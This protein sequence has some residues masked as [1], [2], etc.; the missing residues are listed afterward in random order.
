[1][2]GTRSFTLSIDI[3]AKLKDE[4]NQSNLVEMLLWKHY[5][6]KEPENKIAS[7]VIEQVKEEIAVKNEQLTKIQ[8]EAKEYEAIA[9][10]INQY[11]MHNA[12]LKYLR[13]CEKL[14]PM[15]EVIET[16]T[17]LTGERYPLGLTDAEV[18]EVHALIW[19]LKGMEK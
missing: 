10:Q 5:A 1:M 15:I 19:K 8:R 4:P 14:P 16:Y 18:K 6:E 9:Q 2:K 3:I 12:F 7:Q 17:E 11:G 13:N